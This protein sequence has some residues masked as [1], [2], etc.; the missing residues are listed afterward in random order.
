[1][2][3]ELR[4]VYLTAPEGLEANPVGAGGL[5]L[6]SHG[7]R[8][9]R[10]SQRNNDHA[11]GSG[12]SH[13]EL[14]ARKLANLAEIYLQQEGDTKRWLPHADTLA[15][16]IYL[17][18]CGTGDATIAHM[19]I[20]ATAVVTWLNAAMFC[21]GSV[22]YKPGVLMSSL[23][24]WKPIETGCIVYFTVEYSARLATCRA[25]PQMLTGG[26]VGRRTM[27]SWGFEPLNLVDLCAIV[28][29]HVE[30]ISDELKGVFLLGGDEINVGTW[31]AVLRVLRLM[32]II[33]VLKLGKIAGSLTIM[34]A[35]LKLSSDYL[36]TV[37]VLTA[38]ITIVFGGLLYTTEG[39][40]TTAAAVGETGILMAPPLHP[41]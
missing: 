17:A 37:A 19:V 1:M 38:T 3:T 2:L 27:L 22:E 11:T 24:A 28:P 14:M 20:W 41:Y 23:Q 36:K 15:A 6:M 5:L 31:S 33:R 8:G 9:I 18:A 25:C 16:Q 10:G 13:E 7:M 34:G 12:F 39:Q 26:K 30:W 32:R 21:L 4:T 35:G 29:F 40:V